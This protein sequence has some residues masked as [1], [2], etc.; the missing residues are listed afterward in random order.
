MTFKIGQYAVCPGHGVGQILDI[1]EKDLGGAK[2][3]FYSVKLISNGMKVLVPTDTNNGIRNLVS[4]NE[5]S[6]VYTLLSDHNVK[7]DTSTWN[8]RHREY[9]N[10]V[11]TGSLLEIADV[12]RALFLLKDQK[13]LSFGEKKMLDQCKDL[14][15]LEISISN[16]KE[17]KEV[18]SSIDSLFDSK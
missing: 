4:V 15:A 1:E 5:I 17:K 18:A 14:L 8:R 12:L 6:D 16:G 10:K 9:M 3:T 11:K 7:V 2:K 13:S